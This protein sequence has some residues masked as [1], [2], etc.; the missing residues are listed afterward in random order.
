MSR[1][2]GLAIDEQLLRDTAAR[3]CDAATRDG[4]A[5]WLRAVVDLD[6]LDPWE[7]LGFAADGGPFIAW[8]DP[9][10][11][12]S[13][14]AGLAGGAEPLDP[15]RPFAAAEEVVAGVVDRLI[16]VGDIAPFAH[17]PVVLAAL[18]HRTGG[19]PTWRGLPRA[20]VA[21]P[22]WFVGHAG[23]RVLAA[24]TPRVEPRSAPDSVADRL[25][26][27]R[28]RIAEAWADVDPL[29][30]FGI[31]GAAD[32]SPPAPET[33][34]ES[35]LPLTQRSETLDQ[36]RDRVTRAT[37]AFRA[38]GL[39]KV[40][41]ARSETRRRFD[42]APID[43][44]RVLRQLRQTNPGA[45]C[46]ALGTGRHRAFVGA[47]PETLVEVSG[48]LLATMALAGTREAGA[49][50]A[51]AFVD[52]PKNRAEHDEVVAGIREGLSGLG[53]VRT[54]VAPAPEP[55]RH[56]AIEHLRT[57]I[58]AQLPAARPTALIA[59]AAALHPTA[60]IGG[61]PRDAAATW[62]AAHEPLDR[63][64]YAAPFG[65]LDARGDGRL[66]A[67]LRCGRIDGAEAEL[68]AGAG[69]VAGSDPDDEWAETESKLAP[70][71]TALFHALNGAAAQR[72]AA[73]TGADRGGA[74]ADG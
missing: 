56:G 19:E 34:V 30:L 14:V 42:G 53:A 3:A 49:G 13:F 31:D 67:T 36:W 29:R 47:T 52:D 50:D 24:L 44:T 25:L 2:Q 60:A 62:L 64:L 73:A 69:I 16:G 27:L 10:D 48:R 38:D 8:H 40:V 39:R 45:V 7:L 20:T 37:D 65:W 18:P 58:H 12:L 71:R 63:G 32:H 11:Q 72:L 15:A 59:A 33:A 68:F 22:E 4:R 1:T 26:G 9:T 54:D 23:G 5:V 74:D 28:D 46:Y 66:I 51:A 70:M 41:C 21:V 55:V 57:S 35:V 17:L 61:R 43:A 6:P